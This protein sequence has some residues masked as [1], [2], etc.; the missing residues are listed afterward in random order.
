M[1]WLCARKISQ[2]KKCSFGPL[3]SRPILCPLHSSIVLVKPPW[4]CSWSS[5]EHLC[6]WKLHEHAH[7]ALTRTCAW[8]RH[9]HDHNWTICPL[10][11]LKMNQLDQIWLQIKCKIP[12]KLTCCDILKTAAEFILEL[13]T[14]TSPKIK[15]CREKTDQKI[16]FKTTYSNSEW[17]HMRCRPCVANVLFC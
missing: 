7:E 15:L 14:L 9:A 13:L 11:G 12:F 1:G 4:A 17:F 6:S 16:F 2:R 8:R 3:L 10:H 5:H